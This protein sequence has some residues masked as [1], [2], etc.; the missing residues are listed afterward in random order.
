MGT[1]YSSL[2]RREGKTRVSQ[3]FAR[4]TIFGVRQTQNIGFKNYAEKNNSNVKRKIKEL[5]SNGFSVHVAAVSV[6]VY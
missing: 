4:D 6:H 5:R 1:I 2:V 3:K